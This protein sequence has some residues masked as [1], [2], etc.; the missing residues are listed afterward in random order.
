MFKPVEIYYEKKSGKGDTKQDLF[1]KWL[2]LSDKKLKKFI[3]KAEKK[4]DE[5]HQ[6]IL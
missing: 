3:K 1:K 5:E 4:Y 6:V 2:K